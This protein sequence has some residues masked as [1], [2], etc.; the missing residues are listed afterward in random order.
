MLYEG[1]FGDLNEIQKE[2]LKTVVVAA[3]SLLVLV[4]DILDLHK[5]ELGKLKLNF[6]LADIK[7]TVDET[8]ISTEPITSRKGVLVKNLISEKFKI[9]ID[10]QRMIQVLTNLIKNSVDFVPTEG[11]IITI[12]LEI[13][14]HNIIIMVSDNG[15]GIPSDKMGNLFKKFYQVDTSLTRERGG[16]GLGLSICKSI[17]ELHGGQIWAESEIGKGTTMKIR[18]PI[19]RRD[20]DLIGKKTIS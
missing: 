17:I 8:I 3:K 18:L 12:Q 11:G 14:S 4:Q 16:S 19:A 20:S 9:E 7:E 2:K 5:A 15:C 1:V 10:K 13:K 6:E